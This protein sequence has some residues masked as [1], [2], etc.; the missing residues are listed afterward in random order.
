[1]NKDE[2]MESCGGGDEEVPR[3]AWNA[4]LF[5]PLPGGQPPAATV[6]QVGHML[7][8]GVEGM[9]RNAVFQG[10]A[11]VQHIHVKAIYVGN[12]FDVGKSMT[13]ASGRGVG[14]WKSRLFGPC[15][16][17]SSRQASA[18]WAPKKW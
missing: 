6:L 16:M 8:H 13:R 4:H 7:S 10:H 18:I 15:E 1:M 2:D 12:A 17:A 3:G 9:R 14:P 5:P 11:I